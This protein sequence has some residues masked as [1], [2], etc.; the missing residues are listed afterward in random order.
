LVPGSELLS[1][2]DNGEAE[3]KIDLKAE[4]KALDDV[5]DYVIIDTAPALALLTGLALSIADNVVVP[6]VADIY[7][8]QGLLG[9]G[10]LVADVNPNA[11]IIGILLTR[12]RGRL[13]A[14]RRIEEMSKEV[15]GRMGVKV[16]KTKIREGITVVEAAMM[17]QGLFSYDVDCKSNVAQDYALFM[18]EI[19]AEVK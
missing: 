4:L 5:I 8:I 9:V 18:K 14:V 19:L 15:A 2:V 10:E 16:F 3:I 13:L 12:Y 1:N 6:V 17:Q 11:T 7:N